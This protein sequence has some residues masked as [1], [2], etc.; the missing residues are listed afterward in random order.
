VNAVAIENIDNNNDENS[1][2]QGATYL[3]CF[4]DSDQR[5]LPNYVQ[6]SGDGSDFIAACRK[7]TREKGGKVFAMQ[8]AYQCFYGPDDD[9]YARYGRASECKH[10]CG[11]LKSGMN[12]GGY[13]QQD[14]Y[15]VSI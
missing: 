13:W 2:V 15:K 14:V 12:C 7:I 3:G 8:D 10:F 9:N 1:K 6:L 5:A 11:S 4:K